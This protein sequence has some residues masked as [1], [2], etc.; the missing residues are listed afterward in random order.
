MMIPSTKTD[1]TTAHATTDAAIA[2]IYAAAP[3]I[4]SRA[5]STTPQTAQT[6]YFTVTGRVKIVNIVGEVTVEL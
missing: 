6:A 4:V 1:V 5:A 2:A 3:R